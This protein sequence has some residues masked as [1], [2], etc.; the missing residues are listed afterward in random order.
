MER[1]EPLKKDFNML[2][3][4]LIDSIVENDGKKNYTAYFFEL[5]YGKYAKWQIK[6]RQR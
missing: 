2:E 1:I 4:T 6:R 3:L 5:R